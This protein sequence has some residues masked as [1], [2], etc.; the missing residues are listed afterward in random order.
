MSILRRIRV[1]E[2][3]RLEFYLQGPERDVGSVI[4]VESLISCFEIFRFYHVE[5][6]KDFLFWLL[7]KEEIQHVGG[8]PDF[9][10]LTQK[11][12]EIQKIE[13][14]RMISLRPIIAKARAAQRWGGENSEPSKETILCLKDDKKSPLE[15][16]R[17]SSH[18]QMK[19]LL[20][21]LSLEG[22]VS[23]AK[24]VEVAAAVYP[25]MSEAGGGVSF[26]CVDL[27]IERGL[28]ETV[29]SAEQGIVYRVIEALEPAPVKEYLFPV[30]AKSSMRRPYN[31]V[32]RPRIN[33]DSWYIK[34]QSISVSAV[35]RP[36]PSA[37]VSHRQRY[38]R[39][40]PCQHRPSLV[41]FQEAVA[42]LE[43]QLR[44]ALASS[45]TL[46]QG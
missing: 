16:F 18:A 28:L 20:R 37:A 46:L 38:I 3:L 26:E 5:A 4:S 29:R 44:E 31:F 11:G 21:R 40:K 2:F 10:C 42:Q 9:Y 41:H 30:R 1:P 19:D 15:F 17:S 22:T 39:G 27:L 24:V 33:P 43:V 45:I 32:R 12:L 14:D 6:I 36:V 35:P 13:R 7:H 23:R 34:P 25:W 8:L